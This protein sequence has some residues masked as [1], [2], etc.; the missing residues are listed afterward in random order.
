MGAVHAKMD[1]GVDYRRHVSAPRQNRRQALPPSTSSASAVDKS[2]NRI[3]GKF[4]LDIPPR[5][6]AAP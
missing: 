6:I 1:M 2:S 3:F 5:A 4:D